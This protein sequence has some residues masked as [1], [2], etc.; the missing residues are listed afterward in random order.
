MDL[1][2]DWESFIERPLDIDSLEPMKSWYLEL[3]NPK[4]KQRKRSSPRK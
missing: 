1:I 4:K 3:L 2:T